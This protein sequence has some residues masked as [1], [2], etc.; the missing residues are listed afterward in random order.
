MTSILITGASS[1]IGKGLALH[2]AKP[3]T[4]LLLL[5]R[6][7]ERL[8][9][10]K[11]DC[12]MKGAVV[13]IAS[14]PVENESAM[15]DWLITRDEKTPIDMVIAN[16]GI[17]KTSSNLADAQT[18]KIY[19]INVFGLLN[20]IEPIIPRMQQRKSGQLVLMSSLAGFYGLPRSIAYCA[21]KAAVKSIAQSLRGRLAKEGIKVNL[22]CPGFV[23]TPLT[24]KNPFPMPL[25]MPVEKACRIITNGI[26]KNKA[27][28]VFPFRM[29]F[30]LKL[31][32]ILPAWLADRMTRSLA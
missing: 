30:M 12:E 18:R 31:L 5:G 3:E 25:L 13:E 15:R 17:S 24:Q 26:S 6:N 8:K 10:V 28:I 14:I 29:F 23:D 16:A 20:T 7:E 27:L 2:Y 32:N 22:I 19:A 9:Q 21:S 4:Q 1:G 11:L